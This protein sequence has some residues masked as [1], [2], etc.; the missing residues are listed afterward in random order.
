MTKKTKH[1][2]HLYNPAETNVREISFPSDLNGTTVSLKSE[3]F[4]TMRRVNGNDEKF[5]LVEDTLEILLAWAKARHEQDKEANKARA[6]K[7]LADAKK[8][9]ELDNFQ[10][11]I[12]SAPEIK[13]YATENKTFVE[14]SPR[15]GNILSEYNSIDHADGP[16]AG[17]AKLMID[18][19]RHENSPLVI[20]AFGTPAVQSGQTLRQ[21]VDSVPA[22]QG[23]LTGI[24]A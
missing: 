1:T 13:V 3:F 24:R 17:M 8:A 19:G 18:E 21:I 2:K 14:K 16:I 4:R 10:Q 20:D 23:G 11:S 12:A 5:E 22:K 6:E 9:A 15:T 7:E